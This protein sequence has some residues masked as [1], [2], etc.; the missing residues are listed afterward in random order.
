[1]SKEGGGTSFIYLKL[2]DDGERDETKAKGEKNSPH[3][4]K[5][6]AIAM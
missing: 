5:T 3:N 6:A 1:M 2:G 4:F